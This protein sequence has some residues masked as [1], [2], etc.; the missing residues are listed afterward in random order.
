[1]ADGERIEVMP[2]RWPAP[3]AV[4]AVTTL[5]GGGVSAGP[6]A[7]LNLGGHVGDRSEHVAE[8][9][10]RVRD[11]LGLPAEPTWL[12]QVHGVRCV[13]LSEA[14]VGEE[15]DGS[16][17]RSPGRVCAVLTADC[18][19]LF[20]C[21]GAGGQVGLFHVGWRGLAAGIVEHAL[22]VF[23]SRTAVLG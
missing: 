20:L 12:N 11:G 13:D 5:R 14:G 9:R 16:Y 7:S 18:L 21:D 23:A 17:T 22:S 6:Y 8:N 4:R 15:A 1:M 2:T 3:P 10:R 19:P